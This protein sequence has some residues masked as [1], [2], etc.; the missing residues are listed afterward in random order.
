MLPHG[1]E[2]VSPQPAP[3]LVLTLPVFPTSSVSQR[4]KKRRDAFQEA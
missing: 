1:E 4:A 2:T 3:R